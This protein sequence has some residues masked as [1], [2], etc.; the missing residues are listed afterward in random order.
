MLVSLNATPTNPST[1][2]RACCIYLLAVSSVP[3]G[4]W[5]SWMVGTVFVF[6]CFFLQKK[7]KNPERREPPD[8]LSMIWYAD[9]SRFFCCLVLLFLSC[10]LFPKNPKTKPNRQKG[11][12]C[13]LCEATLVDALRR[14]PQFGNRVA[15]VTLTFLV[16]GVGMFHASTAFVPSTTAMYVSMVGFAAWLDDNDVSKSPKLL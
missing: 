6:F 5:I 12:V 3:T 14:S 1:A 7:K 4:G 10:T 9:N 8:Q 2:L 13:A 15:T 16:L 11:L